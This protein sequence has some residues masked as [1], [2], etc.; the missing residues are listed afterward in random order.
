LHNTQCKKHLR[1]VVEVVPV[2]ASAN[3]VIVGSC[4]VGLVVGVG[5][6]VEVLTS[7]GVLG[8]GSGV[9]AGGGLSVKS[10]EHCLSVTQLS[11]D[12]ARI[13]YGFTSPPLP[14]RL[15][16]A[17]RRRRRA[18]EVQHTARVM[19]M[20]PLTRDPSTKGDIT[21]KNASIASEFWFGILM[22]E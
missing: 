2:V 18:C 11:V 15:A 1:A 7:R 21:E 20:R 19:M 10:R 4:V 13:F 5:R 14:S 9:E 6:L 3:P 17:R 22:M 16:R 8:S 12:A